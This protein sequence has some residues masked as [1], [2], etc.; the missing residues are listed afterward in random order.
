MKMDVV[1]FKQYFIQIHVTCYIH[2]EC[3]LQEKDL[4]ESSWVV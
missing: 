2:S 1:W 3:N 4:V